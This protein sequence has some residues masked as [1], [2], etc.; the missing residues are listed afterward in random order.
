LAMPSFGTLGEALSGASGPE[1]PA[2]GRRSN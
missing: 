2:T 1:S